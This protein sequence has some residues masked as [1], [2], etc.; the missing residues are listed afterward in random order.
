ML[1]IYAT[2][3]ALGAA[4]ILLTLFVGDSDTDVDTDVEIETDVGAGA[5]VCADVAM[6]PG[7]GG[8]GAGLDVGVWLP[9]FSI[10]FWVFFACFFGVTGTILTILESG[11]IATFITS[12]VLG[13]S[14]GWLAAYAMYRLSREQVSSGVTSRDYVGLSGKVLLSIN[15]GKQGKIRC[16][17][18]GSYVDIEAETDSDKSISKG[19]EVLIIEMNGHIAKV[20]KA[21]TSSC[22][23]DE[24][25]CSEP[26]KG[27]ERQ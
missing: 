14:T 2:F 23:D 16:F 8:S 1:V 3:G 19:A 12:L 10:R 4:L 17:V 24:E 15:K 5:D 11:F 13:I 27:K 18:K 22:E 21:P 25:I 6:D 7:E 20:V 9:F 26:E